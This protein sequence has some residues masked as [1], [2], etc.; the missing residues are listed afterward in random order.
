M[1]SLIYTLCM[2]F[3]M[4][5]AFAQQP[6]DALYSLYGK[7]RSSD[8]QKA[9]TYAGL[10]L[11]HCDSTSADDTAARLRDELAEYYENTL[12]LYSKAIEQRERSLEIYRRLGDTHKAAV[13]EFILGRLNFEIG[14]Y[15]KTLRYTTEALDAFMESGDS[16]YIRDCYNMLGIVNYF[17]K[18]YDQAISYFKR[19]AS[20]AEAAGDSLRLLV[21]LNNLAA[22]ENNERA[23]TAK[24]RT[25]IRESISMCAKM[26][27]S[28]RLFTM[29]MNLANSYLS[30]HQAQQAGNVVAQLKPLASDIRQKGLYHFLNGGCFFYMEDYPEAIEEMKKAIGYFEQGEFHQKLRSAL[31]I[32]YSSYSSLGRWQDA[33]NA[34]EY[35]VDLSEKYD[36]DDIY[37]QV[38]KFQ[39]E[40]IS[41]Q[42]YSDH[43]RK[44]NRQIT[45]GIVILIVFSVVMSSIYVKW[46]RKAKHIM[47]KEAALRGQK[48]RLELDLTDKYHADKTV[49]NAI[50]RLNRLEV[51]DPDLKKEIISI[52]S[53][54]SGTKNADEW[55]EIRKFIPDFN[56]ESF[57]RLIKDYP[58][59]TVNERRLCALLNKNMTTKDISMITKQSVH[60]I[61]IARARLRAKFGLTKSP[62]SLQEFLSKYN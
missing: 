37:Y 43:L 55:N 28:T 62:M 33:F 25:L 4:L 41:Q 2:V 60:S 50:T 58:N 34:I 54:L 32:L 13:T 30:T 15:H 6:E 17:C 44:R 52:S 22:Y 39:N 14:Q 61:T 48:E 36:D 27:D 23:D 10:Y 42:L 5:P 46:R 38:F 1:T 53:E 47:E 26:G 24:A 45:A 16:E 31:V 7:Y 18:E 49:E 20:E 11:S 3:L 40:I 29:Y 19:C 9:M 12:F 56:S 59:L 21:A 35:Y 8:R 57:S 51:K